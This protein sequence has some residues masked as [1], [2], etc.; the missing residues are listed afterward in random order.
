[1]NIKALETINWLSGFCSRDLIGTILGLLMGFIVKSFY[2]KILLKILIA[3]LI[4][5]KI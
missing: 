3:P 5:L 1:M 4:I 2:L